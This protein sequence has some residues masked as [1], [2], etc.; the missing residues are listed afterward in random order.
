MEYLFDLH[1]H[2]SASHDGCMDI[3]KIVET[4]K[5]KGLSGVAICDHEKVLENPCVFEDFIVIPGVEFSTEYGHL[6]GLF[7]KEPIDNGSFAD[8]AMKIKEQGGLCVLAHPFERNFPEEKLSEAVYLLDGIEVFNSRACGKYADANKRAY[9]FAKKHSLAF[10][11]GSD[12]HCEKEIGN[13]YV[14]LKADSPEP[15]KIKEALAKNERGVCGKSSKRIYTAKSQLK[16]LKRQKA[17]IS[18]YMKWTAFAL[19]CAIK[20]IICKGEKVC[21]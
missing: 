21:H 18:S 16:K 6:L 2:S 15:E 5:K 9:A 3:E 7:V 12:A 8:T 13:A 17:G 4:A 10:F 19:K 14:C 11:A 1:I 20:D